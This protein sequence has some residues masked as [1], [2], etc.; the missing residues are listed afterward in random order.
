MDNPPF[1]RKYSLNETGEH[2][3]LKRCVLASIDSMIH[4]GGYMDY[5]DIGPG[6]KKNY[7]AGERDKP[8]KFHKLHLG[9]Q[10]MSHSDYKTGKKNYVPPYKNMVDK[11]VKPCL[12]HYAEMWGCT[13]FQVKMYWF[14]QYYN[15]ADF[16]W[17]THEGCNM[18][19]IY[20]LE[21]PSKHQITEFF[22]F[23]TSPLQLVEGDVIV[24]PAM[25]PHRSPPIN[26]KDRKTVIGITGEIH[27]CNL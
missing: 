20:F 14:A 27:S 7:E 8:M 4:N 5:D 10:N 13:E 21:T 12:Q 23:D 9:Y 6:T 25:L 17:H 18:S 2:P 15:E 3:L 1:V 19:A 16:S 22:G 26:N 11:A 24:F